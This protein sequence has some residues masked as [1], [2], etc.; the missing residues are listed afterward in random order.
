M[1]RESRFA[2]ASVILMLL[3]AALSANSLYD[4]ASSLRALAEAGDGLLRA[5]GYTVRC[6]MSRST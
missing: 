4:L 1:L 2:G 3:A 6:S 5:V